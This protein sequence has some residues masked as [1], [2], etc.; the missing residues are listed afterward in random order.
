MFKEAIKFINLKE[1]KLYWRWP[2]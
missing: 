2:D 1:Y